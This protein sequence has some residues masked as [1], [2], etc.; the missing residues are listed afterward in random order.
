MLEWMQ[1][2]KK[3]LVLTVWVSVIAL[4]FAGLV[5]WGQG[6]FSSNFSKNVA[7][8]GNEYI[9]QE[10]FDKHFRD[11][12]DSINSANPN[13][14]AL[15]EQSA[16]E[17]GINTIVLQQLVRNKLL[18][19]YARDL[20][21]SVSDKDIIKYL[22]NI[23]ELQVDGVFSPNL[24][25]ELL[26]RNGTKSAIFESRLKNELLLNKV[27]SMT[28]FNPTPIEVNN[29]LYTNG[30][31]QSILVSFI[32]ESKIPKPNTNISD[33][34]LKPFWE[35]N[36]SKYL[37]KVGFKIA[38]INI[39]I[40]SIP[41]IQEDLEQ[42]YKDN[43]FNYRNYKD[44]EAAKYFVKKDFLTQEAQN[45]SNIA[46]IYIKNHT[47]AI[48]KYPNYTK[49]LSNLDENSIK[50]LQKSFLNGDEIK[51]IP[52]HYMEFDEKDA[53]FLA[54]N[55]DKFKKENGLLKPLNNGD[56]II[57]PL[58]ISKSEAK[59]L[60]FEQSKDEVRSDF[61]ESKKY[62]DIENYLKTQIDKTKMTNLG[63]LSYLDMEL[64][65]KSGNSNALFKFLKDKL[66]TLSS[67]DVTKIVQ[68]IFIGNNNK[69]YLK[70]DDG[71]L[72]YSVIDYEFPNYEKSL[73]YN[74][75]VMNDIEFSKN[76]LLTKSLLT[77]LESKYRIEFIGGVN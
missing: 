47:D 52:I 20:G 46:Y 12:I 10:E 40:D 77:Y 7:K 56:S 76:N 19:V 17:M 48:L 61:I 2:H 26:Q 64:D 71:F 58:I 13:L 51:N 37:S 66:P 54:T 69:G 14:K 53:N 3:Y 21:L 4:V 22:K 45:I 24:Y 35:K 63:M 28:S 42:Y 29:A 25:K 55:I 74:H 30:M 31:Q 68:Q 72:L 41:F 23:P 65:S 27:L 38:Y 18:L 59:E 50:E 1:K 6:G 75:F 33:V 39:G 9:T 34:D 5:E 16:R 11:T 57:I 49:G 62:E 43:S 36:R 8:V 67:N 70:V 73:K 60:D 15:D 32:A 44:F